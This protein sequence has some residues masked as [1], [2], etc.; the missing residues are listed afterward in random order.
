MEALA[1]K[2]CTKM[3]QIF[4]TIVYSRFILLSMIQTAANEAAETWFRFLVK[5]LKTD[6]SSSNPPYEWYEMGFL[7]YCTAPNKTIALCFDVPDIFRQRLHDTLNF[8]RLRPEDYNK[9]SIHIFLIK[10][11]VDLYDDSV[12]AIRDVIRNIEKVCGSIAAFQRWSRIP[13]NLHVE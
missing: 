12:W 7:T 2:L 3:T 6:I 1:A 8:S 5:K 13:L 4:S 9:S 11:A 10:E